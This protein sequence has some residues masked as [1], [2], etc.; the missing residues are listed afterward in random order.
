MHYFRP[1]T[2]VYDARSTRRGE[3]AA[4]TRRPFDP[5]SL[6]V[7]A[8]ALTALGQTAAAEKDRAAAV[9][10]WHGDKSAFS[11]ALI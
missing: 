1:V 9:V 3:S 5:V 8:D 10:R 7:R 4:L 6:S 11:A 2:R